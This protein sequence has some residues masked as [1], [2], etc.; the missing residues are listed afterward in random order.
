MPAAHTNR[1]GGQPTRGCWEGSSQLHTSWP[2]GGGGTWNPQ[3]PPEA[4]LG[5]PGG[6]KQG[7]GGERRLPCGRGPGCGPHPRESG[8]APAGAN[9]CAP[10]SRL[11]RH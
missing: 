6:Q 2:W 5:A 10:S 1:R 3:E 9:G 11:G 4:G 8:Q 7:G